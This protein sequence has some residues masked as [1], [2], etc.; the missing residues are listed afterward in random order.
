MHYEYCGI[1]QWT[2]ARQRAA[3]V[4]TGLVL[5]VMMATVIHSAAATVTPS[6]W[7][8]LEEMRPPCKGDSCT[9]DL[10]APGVVI[11]GTGFAAD[12]PVQVRFESPDGTR[13]SMI[14]KTDPY[15]AAGDI[16]LL[17]GERV[18]NDWLA[19]PVEAS[20]LPEEHAWEVGA[21]PLTDKSGVAAIGSNILT[22]CLRRRRGGVGHQ[23]QL[24]AIQPALLSGCSRRETARVRETVPHPQHDCRPVGI[25]AQP[26]IRERPHR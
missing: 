4:I 11:V 25:S 24:A 23:K 7:V 15:S 1:E 16:T 13:P 26:A 2:S 20:G 14:Y 9:R 21:A 10:R 6:I 18:C 8:E 3:A 17:T 22:L 5:T 12:L 19:S